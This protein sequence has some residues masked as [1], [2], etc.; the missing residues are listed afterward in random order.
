MLLILQ[1][2]F[3][4]LSAVCVA[5]FMPIGAFFGFIP[6]IGVALAAV[7]FFMLMK[8]CKQSLQ[9]QANK[10]EEKTETDFFNPPENTEPTNPENAE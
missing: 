9:L 7:M 3:T 2:T 10:E 6:A 4:I 8:L 5:A 1:I